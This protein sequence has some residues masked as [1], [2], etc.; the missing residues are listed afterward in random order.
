MTT[1]VVSL[2]EIENLADLRADY[3]LA[4]IDGPFGKEQR[5]EDLAEKN[6][7]LLLK[8][9]MYREKTAATLVNRGGRPML[10]FPAAHEPGGREYALTPHVVTL[11]P[12]D[13]VHTI[14]YDRPKAG[15][16]RVAV[17]FLNYHLRTPLMRDKNLWRA[18]ANAF[19]TKRPANWHEASRE[20]DVYEGFSFRLVRHAGRLFVAI[21]LTCRYGENAWLVDRYGDTD[22][23][24]LR[25]RHLLY[26][27]GN[28]WFTAQL[29]GLTGNPIAEQKFQ[30]HGGGPVAN[31]Y[32]YTRQKAGKDAP[33]WVK[34]LDP[35]SPAILFRYPGNEQQRY[36]AAA[37]CK[38]LLR[39]EDQ[40]IRSVHSRSIRPPQK[41]F[42]T[43]KEVVAQ[44]FS[45]AEIG[46]VPIR[47]Q[48]RALRAE[49]RTFF[50]PNQMFGNGRVLR[51][52]S[53]TQADGVE[54]AQLGT[55]RMRFTLDPQCGLAVTKPFG[56]QYLFV[57]QS[58]HRPL[59]EDFK[60]R[61]EKTVRQIAQAPFRMRTILYRDESA[62]TLKSQVDAVLAAA[63]LAEIEQGHGVLI[64]PERRAGDLHHHVKQRLGDRLRVQCAA[65]EKLAGFYEGRP[66]QGQQG[67]RLRGDREQHY[68]SYLRY[69][70]L[71]LLIVNR[72]W[73]WVLEGGT[74]H[75]IYVGIDVLNNTAA[76][77]FFYEGG[78]RCF[79]RTQRSR[80]RERLL[81]KEV[82]EALYDHLKTDLPDCP[83]PPRSI[84]LRRDGRIFESEWR[85]GQD[86]VTQLIRERLLPRDVVFGAVEIHKHSAVG[87]RLA[88]ERQGGLVN[89][90]I[91][92]WFDIDG[93]E[94]VVCTTG[95]PFRLNGTAHPL[96]VKVARGKLDLPQVLEDVFCMSQLCWMTP[97]R[98][99]R[100]PI[101]LKLCDEFLRVV[102]AGS[103]EEEVDED[104]SD[105]AEAVTDEA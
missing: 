74:H 72:Q 11:R 45:G 40:Q 104:E 61:L 52:L 19:F 3:R 39:T 86:A 14:S 73:P 8:Q 33:N 9:F 18:G 13:E 25:M 49:A 48:A 83:K 51:V 16:E 12:Q 27:F 103:E 35:D 53:P 44:H 78:R 47:V 96:A 105:A 6:L 30:P 4:E 42:E 50:V 100:L 99:I 77:A 60:D 88:A 94:G 37:L 43:M 64:L 67:S 54:L 17:A 26:H 90:D 55:V 31:V 23:R 62:R 56:G 29:L 63:D 98:C 5:D 79:V 1:H 20:A 32:D 24:A 36:G 102:A 22:M 7:N 82:Q 71:G 58:M 97:D 92:S 10:A 70:A 85:G 28:E 41:R 68:T 21:K 75:D 101:D 76:F 59:A 65:A 2:Y 34:S 91:G 46:G 87:L 93:T 38:L 80:Q 15:E 81:R 69:A 95:S 89:P 84:V 66:G 57:P